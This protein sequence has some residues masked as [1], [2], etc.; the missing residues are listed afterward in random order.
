MLIISVFTTSCNPTYYK[1]T[2]YKFPGTKWVSADPD[3][4]F[5]V[6]EYEARGATDYKP[7]IATRIRG[8]ITVDG[9][10]YD[11]TLNTS[12][13]GTVLIAL[14]NTP[15]LGHYEADDI[16]RGTGYFSENEMRIAIN[17]KFTKEGWIDPSI[18]QIIF[19]REDIEE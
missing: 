14:T 10:S 13:T 9:S 19:I 17:R 16:I 6:E 4:Y 5:I 18:K 12:H 2:P 1:P 8:E 15:T 11:I 7:Y 3:I